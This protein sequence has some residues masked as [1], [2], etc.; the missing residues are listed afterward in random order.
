[1]ALNTMMLYLAKGPTAATA[2]SGRRSLARR[3]DLGANSLGDHI[4][5]QVGGKIVEIKVA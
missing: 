3:H 4:P 2:M 1:M 5:L